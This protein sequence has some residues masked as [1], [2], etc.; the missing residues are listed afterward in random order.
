MWPIA[1]FAVLGFL[2]GNLVGLT[3]ESVTGTAVGLLFAFGGGSAIAFLHR[4]DPPSRVLAGQAVAALS[5]SCLLGVYTGIV[6]S[7]YQLLS[8]RRPLPP[9]TVAVAELKYN[10]SAALARADAIDQHLANRDLDPQQAY[11][12]LYGVFRTLERSADSISGGL[13]SGAISERQACRGYEN[14]LIARDTT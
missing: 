8:P 2:V 1:G 7:E 10:R 4:L 6:V 9:R 12:Q 14:L 11:N 5:F 13:E 3:A